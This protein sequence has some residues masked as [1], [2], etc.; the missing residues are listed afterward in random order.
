MHAIEK[1]AVPSR[2]SKPRTE[3]RVAA[4][5]ALHAIGTPH[6]RDLIKTATE[7]D[8][9]M[10]VALRDLSRAESPS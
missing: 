6:A 3:V 7:K 8:P 9:V 1:H 10:R 4:Y 5:R 2:F